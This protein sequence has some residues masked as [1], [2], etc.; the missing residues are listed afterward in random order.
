M[1]IS[2]KDEPVRCLLFPALDPHLGISG[3]T[4]TRMVAFKVMNVSLRNIVT[5]YDNQESVTHRQTHTDGQIDRYTG[6][7]DPYVSFCF[8]DDTKNGSIPG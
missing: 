7:S 4:T 3:E 8:T 1:R 5:Y 2:S 6:Q